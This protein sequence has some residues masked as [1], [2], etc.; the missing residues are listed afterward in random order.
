MATNVVQGYNDY[1]SSFGGSY[2]YQQISDPPGGNAARSTSTYP[3]PADL[4]AAAA[5][6]NA[7]S[8]L[9]KQ[10]SRC[11]PDYHAWSPHWCVY[12]DVTDDAFFRKENYLVRN[13]REFADQYRFRVDM[14]EFMP[15]TPAYIERIVAALYD[16]APKRE[17]KSTDL[18]AFSEQVTRA[19]GTNA[20]TLDRFMRLEAAT[21]MTYGSTR[22]LVTSLAAPEGATRAEEQ[23]LGARP[24]LVHYTPLAVIDWDEDDSCELTMARAKECYCRKDNPTDPASPRV[25]YT[26]FIQY[27]RLFARWWV[28]SLTE[29]DK[30]SRWEL[31][32]Q[33]EAQHGLG[34]VPMIVYYW[35]R[36][37]RTMVGSSFIRYMARAEISRFRNES[38]L[39]Y[40]AYMHAHPELVVKT[41]RPDFKEFTTGA[42]HFAKLRLQDAS[43]AGEDAYYLEYPMGFHEGLDKLISGKGDRIKRYASVDPAGVIEPQQDGAN[44][45]SGVSRAWSFG[46][47]EGRVIASLADA[48]AEVE[49]AVLDMASRYYGEVPDE[50]G[51]AFSG[52]IQYPESFDVGATTQ[53]LDEAERAGAT[54]N[55]PTYLR[56]LHKQIVRKNAGDASAEILSKIDGEIDKNPV[57]AEAVRADLADVMQF[58]G[59]GGAAA[60]RPQDV[61][62]RAKPAVPARAR[63]PRPAT[64]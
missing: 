26:R 45:A 8:D 42:G 51:S 16:E 2:G 19:S 17:Y 4:S 60:A 22:I 7:D 49:M 34:V 39:D 64:Y 35:P 56:W 58:P 44:A 28:F 52:E 36:R 5:P 47:S 41:N 55:S 9:F 50:T 3:L 20:M 23:Q 43:Q 10:L 32:D 29:D 63:R 59:G 37:E 33:G 46:T 30:G 6:G 11:H 31:R 54:V 57:L 62:T 27:D 25:E 24:Y 21:L 14:S 48:M 53:L 18:E 40:D 12:R 1:P 61:A 15:D 38:D 13:E